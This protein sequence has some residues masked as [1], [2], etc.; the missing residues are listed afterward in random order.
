M[1]FCYIKPRPASCRRWTIQCTASGP[2]PSCCPACLYDLL[3]DA[4]ERILYWVAPWVK[5]CSHHWPGC[6][7]FHSIAPV[8]SHSVL[9]S[10]FWTLISVSALL[11]ARS[12]PA[13]MTMLGCAS[14]LLVSCCQSAGGLGMAGTWID[15][16][17]FCNI[18]AVTFRTI[19]VCHGERM[20]K[21]PIKGDGHPASNSG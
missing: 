10:W 4:I 12:N 18:D 17:S 5:E 21:F 19:H 16:Q 11:C 15:L 9:W 8:W 14:V 1:T 20:A 6:C 13:R 2:H 7:S 3:L